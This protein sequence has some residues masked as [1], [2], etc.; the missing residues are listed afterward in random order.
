[1]TKK[2]IAALLL[3]CLAMLPLQ[4]ESRAIRFLSMHR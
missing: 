3:I 4:S 1:M 2:L